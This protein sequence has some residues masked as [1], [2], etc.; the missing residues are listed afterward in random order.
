MA[1]IFIEGF[2]HANFYL[3]DFWSTPTIVQTTGRTGNYNASI[4]TLNSIR[5]DLP[6]SPTNTYYFHLRFYGNG[7]RYTI[8]RL[9]NA[10][11]TTICSFSILTQ[12]SLD[13][14]N[15]AGTT[16]ATSSMIIQ[17]NTWTRIEAKI[18]PST[19]A[20]GIFAVKINGIMQSAPVL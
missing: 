19:G 10:A 3:W 1:R 7:G 9:G 5:K 14:V 2:E 6:I 4:G 13:I 16:L 15:Q 18:K 20:D 12:D 11:Y 8:L 17:P